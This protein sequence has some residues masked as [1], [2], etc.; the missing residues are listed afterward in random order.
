MKKISVSQKTENSTTYRVSFNE[1]FSEKKIFDSLISNRFVILKNHGIQTHLLKK[2][3]EEWLKF[4]NDE[5]KF[6]LLRSDIIDEGYVPLYKETA[7]G[8]NFA[9]MKEYFQT[10]VGGFY[11]DYIE[12]DTTKKILN[13]FIDLGVNII[14]IIEKYIPNQVSLLEMVHNSDRH[15]FRVIH[16]PSVEK[17]IKKDQRASEHTDICFLTIIP[18]STGEGLE[19]EKVDGVWYKPKIEKDEILVFNADML[20]IATNSVIKSTKHRVVTEENFQAHSSR[21]SFPVFIHPR[22]EVELKP[23]LTAMSILKKRITEIG[24]NG[25]LLQY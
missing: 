24:F 25:D 18:F 11:P 21:F 13:E 7:V 5:K 2:I 1:P 4:F 8:S 22:R 14:K 23:N 10:H 9:D 3:Y 16:Y 20:E 15:G 6:T 19:L 17:V 12:C